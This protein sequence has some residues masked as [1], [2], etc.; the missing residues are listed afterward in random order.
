MTPPAT[1]SFADSYRLRTHYG[2]L[3]VDGGFADPLL[4]LAAVK[5]VSVVWKVL[6]ASSIGKS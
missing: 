2:C 6:I 5:E 3:G 4:A 1:S